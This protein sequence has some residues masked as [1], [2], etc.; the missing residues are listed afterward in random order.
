MAL[1]VLVLPHGFR[2]D[3]LLFLL[4]SLLSS[5][6]TCGFGCFLLSSSMTLFPWV[7]SDIG[8]FLPGQFYPHPLCI[9]PVAGTHKSPLLADLFV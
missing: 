1:K 9:A 3:H 2:H 6:F 4:E 7:S 5:A 8:P